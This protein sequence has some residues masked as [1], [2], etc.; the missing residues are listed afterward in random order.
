MFKGDQNI[1][2][3][4]NNKERRGDKSVSVIIELVLNKYW[5]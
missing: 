5:Y 3:K 4:I 2:D 1:K